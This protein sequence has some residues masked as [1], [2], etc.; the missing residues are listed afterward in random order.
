MIGMNDSEDLKEA[1][2]HKITASFDPDNFFEKDR[3]VLTG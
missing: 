1:A 2:E 3:N